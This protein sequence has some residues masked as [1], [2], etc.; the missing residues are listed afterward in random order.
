MFSTFAIKLSDYI[1][2]F[3][4]D[5]IIQNGFVN[6]I[7]D[8]TNGAVRQES[9]K[10]LSDFTN[11]CREFFPVNFSPPGFVRTSAASGLACTASK[12][13]EVQSLMSP[14]RVRFVSSPKGNHQL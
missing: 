13:L 6:H 5:E 4:L 14:I 7:A 3:M 8:M 12:V 2:F 1:S 9:N 11:G 10:R